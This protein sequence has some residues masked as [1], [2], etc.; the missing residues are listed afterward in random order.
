MPYLEIQLPTETPSI[1][2]GLIRGAVEPFFRD[3]HAMF[4]LPV[5]ATL[6]AVGCN[7]SIAQ[8]LL[9][10]IGGVSGTLYSTTLGTGAAFRGFLTDYYPW[11]S[12]PRR[13]NAISGDKAA[14]ILYDEYRNPLT[15]A[16]GI[17]V[18]SPGFGK[19]REY[20]PQQRRVQINRIEL[21]ADKRPG[22]GLSE[23]RIHELESQP[24]RPGWPLP[25]TLK[26]IEDKT[27]LTVESLYWGFRES[28]RRLCGDKGRMEAAIRFFSV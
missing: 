9:A 18:F 11:D 26:V 22:R 3:V 8:V 16:T 27:V 24:A 23:E 15:H 6:P 2:E 13:E 5:S 21:G 28:I 17:P 7:L 1:V 10:S 25:P 20:R 19:P 4:Q 12:E 14:Q